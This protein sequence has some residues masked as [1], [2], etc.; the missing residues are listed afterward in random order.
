MRTSVEWSKI[1]EEWRERSHAGLRQAV[2]AIDGVPLRSLDALLDSVDGGHE[3]P[4]RVLRSAF[5]AAGSRPDGRALLATY[6]YAKC[7]EKW[8]RAEGHDE[9]RAV[10]D[11]LRAETL[12]LAADGDEG[13]RALRMVAE[14]ASCMSDAMRVENAVN[15][16]CPIDVGNWAKRI[17]ERTGAMLDAPADPAEPAR[18]LRS[19][20]E[21]QRLYFGAVGEVADSVLEFLIE[22]KPGPGPFGG[23]IESL[24]RAEEHEAVRGDVYESELRA[25][26]A[27]LSALDDRA[28]DPRIWIDAAEVVYLY[29]FAFGG[30]FGD[31]H[32]VVKRARLAGEAWELADG[33]AP[34][35]VEQLYLTDVWERP[36][37]ERPMYAGATL[38]LPSVSVTPTAGEEYTFECEVE[39]R[40]SELGNHHVRV[41]SR[42]DDTDVHDLNQALRRASRSMGEEILRCGDR[43][44]GRFV[45]FAEEVIHGVGAS[46]W[47]PEPVPAGDVV[48]DPTT[49]FHVVLAARGLSIQRAGGESAPA[50][51]DELATAVGG[52][53]RFHPVRHL[54]TSLEEWIRY[55]QP[56]VENLME[57]AAYVDDLAVRTANTT[58]LYM[59]STPEWVFDEYEEMIEFTAS[60]PPLLASWE[61]RVI[62]YESRLE[63]DLPELTRPGATGQ[64]EDAG[65]PRNLD[66]VEIL[67]R[68]AALRELQ[69]RI[70][71][72]IAQFHSPRLVRDRVHREFLDR[73]WTA[74]ALPRLED[75][76]Q[77]RL[78]IVSSLTERLSSIASGIAEENR[79][80]TELY[81][82]LI[83]GA[84][85]AVSLIDLFLWINGEFGVEHQAWSIVETVALLLVAVAMVTIILRQRR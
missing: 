25:H 81:V 24:R 40:L 39:V 44:W 41:H 75:E 64:E 2:E 34:L 15:C 46:L 58:V 79:R 35:S 20:A 14:H 50:R 5:R 85:A 32:E 43:R 9:I 1:A 37:E 22:G 76:L 80:R 66:L 21:T 53:L 33:I 29:P 78:E 73:L 45:D 72:D 30:R 7:L 6:V 56:K 8:E 26:R 47:A 23:T 69:V 10:L 42:L 61:K 59:P 49:D 57:G 63:R 27:T 12:R 16:S 77:R 36:G 13:D 74:A 55:P 71:D 83:L 54:A 60:L 3:E 51:V 48:G 28:P 67:R 18:L 62:D 38:T 82:Q 19:D 84:I 17:V 11:A 31:A 70:R 4:G 68:D 65:L 52:S